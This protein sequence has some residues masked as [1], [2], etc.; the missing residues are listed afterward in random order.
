M[1]ANKNKINIIIGGMS[2]QH[3]ANAVKTTLENIDGVAKADVNLKKN[4]ADITL[5]K[6]DI[7]PEVFHKAIED[8]GYKIVGGTI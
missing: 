5:K 4:C 8:A 6:S 3:C 1:F 7:A 2:C